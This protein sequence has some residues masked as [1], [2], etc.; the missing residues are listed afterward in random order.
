MVD[1]QIGFTVSAWVKL[2]DTNALY[3][4]L[5]QDGVTSENFA[6]EYLKGDNKWS[7]SASESDST[8]PTID[9]ALSDAA[10]AVGVWT[11]LV[12]VFCADPSCLA[13]GD[14]VPGRLF[15]YVDTGSG[16]Q[17]QASQPVFSSP[18]MSTGALEMGRGMFN[19]AET[20]YLNGTIDEVHVYW[21]D[22][23]QPQGA[24]APASTCSIP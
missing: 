8:N 16:L 21:G 14:S 1:T 20:N 2:D 19:G 18:W 6:L 11:H 9:H 15:L 23:C 13:P 12:G 10:P 3:H 22:P 7:F 5:T 24:T 4:V 17:L